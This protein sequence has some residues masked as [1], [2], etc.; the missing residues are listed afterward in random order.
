MTTLHQLFKQTAQIEIPEHLSER[1]LFRIHEE[2]A[3]Q[4]R[5][6]NIAWG[7]IFS[8]S[9]LAFIASGI[10]AATVFAS[11]SFGSYFSLIFSDRGTV[12]TLWKQFLLSL[13][14][15]FPFMEIIIFIASIALVLWSIRK[16]TKKIPLFINQA[17]TEAHLA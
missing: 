9:L 10:H 6:E 7:G 4:V 12:A 14:E 5:R 1:V 13:V 16:L 3:K 11:G 15:S 17:G 2:S 8:A